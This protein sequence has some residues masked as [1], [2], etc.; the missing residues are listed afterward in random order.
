MQNKDGKTPIEIAQ[1]GATKQPYA[2]KSSAELV[3]MIEAFNK[4]K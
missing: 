3:R 1:A 2:F 4:K